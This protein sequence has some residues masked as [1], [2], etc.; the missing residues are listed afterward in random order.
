MKK[1]FISNKI[2]PLNA[3]PITTFAELI[4][5]SYEATRVMAKRGKLPVFELRNPKKPDSRSGEIWIS[6]TEFNRMMD[7]AYYHQPKEKRDAWLLWLGL[8]E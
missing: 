7:R 6:I 2:Y 3:V 1:K 8:T 4:G 5:K